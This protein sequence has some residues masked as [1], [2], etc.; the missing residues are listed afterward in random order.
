MCT[1]VFAQVEPVFLY[2]LSNFTG[3]VPYSW[4]NIR[5]DEE[6]NEIYAVDTRNGDI[7]IFNDK[8]MEVYRF[9]DDGSLG[10]VADVAVRKDGSILV[11][12][13]SSSKSVIVVCNFRGEPLTEIQYNNFPPDFLG[14]LPDQMALRNGRLFLLDSI[15]MRIAITDHMGVFQKGYDLVSLLD[16]DEKKRGQA[17]VGGF[18]VD[19]HGNVLF[20]IPVLFAAYKLLPDGTIKGFGRAG[21]A[22]GSFGVVGGIVSDDRGYFYV[23]DRLKSAILVFD[24]HFRFQ[25]E[26]GYR[27]PRP[28]NLVGPRQLALDGRGRLYVSQLK[29]RGVSVFRVAA[30]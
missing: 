30:N 20:T 25:T 11:L 2:T 24:D 3:P 16:L 21:S 18:S 4:A 8:G 10:P 27:G 13:K 6:R 14:F 12:S 7:R 19:H 17:G 28:E 22:P 15:S 29:N 23:A 9:G 1:T 26:F 5:F